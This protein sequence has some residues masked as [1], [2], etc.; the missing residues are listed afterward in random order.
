MQYLRGT[1]LI[2]LIGILMNPIMLFAAPHE[3]SPAGG[4]W[5]ELNPKIGLTQTEVPWLPELTGK[6]TIEAW[7]STWTKRYRSK[8]PFHSL[9]K[10]T[11]SAA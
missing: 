3:P 4:D 9:G 2:V 6:L 1:F 5:L 11:D 10:Q 8:S 7:I